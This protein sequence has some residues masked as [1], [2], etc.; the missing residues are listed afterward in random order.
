M[1]KLIIIRQVNATVIT[2]LPRTLETSDLTLIPEHQNIASAALQ[3][4]VLV[5]ITMGNNQ[6]RLTY[7]EC[8]L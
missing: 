5:P 7:A 6:T 3:N 1:V 8:S 4:T 2:E